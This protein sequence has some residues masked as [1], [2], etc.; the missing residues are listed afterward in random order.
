M[1]TAVGGMSA[2]AVDAGYARKSIVSTAA[3][4]S[5]GTVSN[6]GGCGDYTLWCQPAATLAT[7]TVNL[8]LDSASQIGD[9]ARVG[10]SKTVT[11][12]TLAGPVSIL[13]SVGTLSANQI[14]SYKKLAADT[15]ALI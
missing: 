3:P 4:V 10:S 7:L 15:W 14:V 12:L 6:P 1:E 9:I 13:D 8:P 11:L 2:A 5:G